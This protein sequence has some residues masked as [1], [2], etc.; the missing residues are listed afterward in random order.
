MSTTTL[1]LEINTRPAP[2]SLTQPSQLRLVVLHDLNEI[3]DARDAWT[4][5]AADHP[6]MRWEWIV[7]WWQEFGADRQAFV[8][9]VRDESD[10]WV[11]IF[12]LQIE[13]RPY[14][15]RVLSNMANGRA[16]SDHVRPVIL[17]GCERESLRLIADWIEW[18]VENRTIDLIEWDGVDVAEPL[19]EQLVQRLAKARIIR[20]EAAIEATWIAELP[21]DWA[22]FEAK[23]KKCFR[24]KMQKARRNLT[25][26]GLN[27]EAI[28]ASHR[29][30]DAWPTFI[31]LHESRRATLGQTGCFQQD[32]FSE[33]LLHAATRMAESGNAVLFLATIDGRPFGAILLMTSGKRAYLYQSGFDPEQR[34]LEPGHLTVTCAVQW[35][36]EQRLTHFDFLRGDEPYKARWNSLREPMHQIRL[37]PRRLAPRLRHWLWTQIHRRRQVRG[38]K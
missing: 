21:E 28:T 3:L 18:Q 14:W 17:P 15:G 11:G 36:I 7:S 24:R 38:I 26:P 4:Q 6:F 29:L 31:A 9:T 5:L 13:R 30:R 8:L 19:M 16:C 27:V 20:Q 10:R 37:Y 34:Q 22:S 1:P 12:P 32:R 25:L 23:T 35:A 2:S 33:F